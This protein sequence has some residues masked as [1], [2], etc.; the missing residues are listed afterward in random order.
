MTYSA[1]DVEE[2]SARIIH[3]R[4]WPG[5]DHWEPPRP[6]AIYS[7]RLVDRRGLVIFGASKRGSSTGEFGL[8]AYAVVT[9][10][11]IHECGLVVPDN[12]SNG[13]LNDLERWAVLNQIET[14]AGPRPWRIV[15]RT[16]FCDPR[17]GVFMQVAYSGAG[18]CIG[19]ELGRTIGLL[20]D[21]VSWRNGG[22]DGECEAW[23]P[24]WGKELDRGRWKRVSPHRPAIRMRAQRVGWRLRFAPLPKGHGKYVGDRQWRG[25]F[26]DTMSLAYALDADR[27]AGF[28][29]HL[30][31]FGVDLAS[32]PVSLSLDD[33][34]ATYA[35]GAVRSI[36][37]LV[38]T[39]DERSAEWFT[40]DSD[41]R[42]QR[43]RVNL[44]STISPGA[45]ATGV[46]ARFGVVAPL[47]KFD[48]S[49]DEH[50]HWAETFHGGWVFSDT[51]VPYGPIN[52]ISFDVSSCY[53]FVA[54]RIGWWEIA[55]AAEIKRARA[56]PAFRKLCQRVTT[57]PLVLL[58]P[59][60][61]R[62]YG[63][64][65]VEG[66]Q[67]DGEIFPVEVADPLRPDGRMEFV[68]LT[69]SEPMFFTAL[70]V[71][72]ACVL[73]GRVPHFS[74]VTRF[75]P[76]GRQE[77][78]RSQ[79]PLLPNLILRANEDPVLPIVAQRQ[80]FKEA[81]DW[82][83]A[84]Q[85]RVFINALVFG[86][87]CRFDERLVKENGLW[88][89]TEVPGPYNF[90]PLASCVSSGAH[91]LLAILERLVTEKGGLIMYRD[92][93]SAIIPARD[94]GGTLQLTDGSFAKMLSLE[95]APIGRAKIT[96]S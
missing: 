17:N 81:D 49:D 51:R 65:L 18:F 59:N 47:E 79:L 16:E 21:H 6:P 72:A 83:K 67:P 46:L 31:H 34:G 43:G 61:W 75:I 29:D 71:L 25:E 26:I 19:A 39:L 7:D 35:A 74:E 56:A 85:L 54:H 73:S 69:S 41:R 66:V 12:L 38:A 44:A 70:D 96:I 11:A 92:T 87:L 57:N 10:K 64:A 28:G 37:A 33:E 89:P 80:F 23:L 48:L 62:R 88:Q 58:D 55:T 24:G 77:G 20:A 36:H 94:R 63:L 30:H 76:V 9:G 52:A 45:L 14:T 84:D 5:L 93:D 2:M 15:P 27:G 95:P 78:L 1:G 32:L 22:G 60:V 53:P 90:F 50:S 8:G 42:Q 82:V 3:F 68:R 13:E 91:L 86:N 4:G 40:T